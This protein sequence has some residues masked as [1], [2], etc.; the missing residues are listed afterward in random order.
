MTSLTPVLPP[1]AMQVH[2]SCLHVRAELG[3][4]TSMTILF[5]IMDREGIKRVKST[6]IY[7]E[8]E[9]SAMNLFPHLFTLPL[10]KDAL[11][12]HPR[13]VPAA[14]WRPEHECRSIQ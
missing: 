14:A 13:P 4:P 11:P 9:T 1:A 3:C 6:T 12:K 10:V 5:A 2:T 7:I 8:M